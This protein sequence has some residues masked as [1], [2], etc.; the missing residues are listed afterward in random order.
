[1]TYKVFVDD[2]FHYQ[3]PSERY[4]AGEYETATEALAKCKKIVR[5]SLESC[6]EPGMTPTEV[7][8]Q[9]VRF[10]YDPWAGSRRC[11]EGT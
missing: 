3:D 9:Y 1:V 11:A 4:C 5:E 6:R 2:N 10:G 7:Y 8:D